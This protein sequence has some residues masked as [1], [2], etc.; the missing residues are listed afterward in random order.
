MDTRRPSGSLDSG[1]ALLYSERRDRAIGLSRDGARTLNLA[2]YR[3]RKQKVELTGLIRASYYRAVIQE[4]QAQ[5]GDLI[6]KAR[7]K[8]KRR[9]IL[10]Q[11]ERLAALAEAA[12]AQLE[13]MTNGGT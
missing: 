13:A 4:C 5:A 3:A 11:V 1:L 8:K 12:A 7:T 10:P 9:V 6:T 2:T